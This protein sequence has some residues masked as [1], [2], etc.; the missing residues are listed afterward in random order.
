MTTPPPTT[1]PPPLVPCLCGCQW[2]CLYANMTA[3]QLEA[4]AKC[5]H[6]SSLKLWDECLPL[7]DWLAAN[8]ESAPNRGDYTS[9]LADK[10]A[11]LSAVMARRDQVMF[12]MRI[13][14]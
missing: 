7:H 2:T 1:T 4:C 8:P 6:E 5:L 12:H 11:T 9:N 3:S 10:Q 14:L 13:A